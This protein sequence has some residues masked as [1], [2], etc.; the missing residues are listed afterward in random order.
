M[1]GKTLIFLRT[2]VLA[3]CEAARARHLGRCFAAV[4]A[5]IRGRNCR[6]SYQG[7]R[8]SAIALQRAL[9]RKVQRRE[10]A[11]LAAE[12]AAAAAAAAAAA[13]ASAR[14]KAEAEAADAS[15]EAQAGAVAAAAAE[16]QLAGEQA[17]LMSEVGRLPPT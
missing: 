3:K 2:G 10:A 17:R 12:S 6:L 16:A 15:A 11:R 4:Q 13:E 5:R 14:A 7:V 8:T 9:R 1:L